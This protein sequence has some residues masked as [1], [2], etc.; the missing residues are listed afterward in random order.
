MILVQNPL[1]RLSG[2]KWLL[3]SAIFCLGFSLT[4]CELFKKL[5]DN[6]KVYKDEKTGLGEIQGP[7][8]TDPVTGETQQIY[9]LVED[10]DTIQWTLSNPEKFPPIQSEA[11]TISDVVFPG[12]DPGDQVTGPR[13]G[14][15]V[16]MVLPFFA[17]QYNSLNANVPT[18]SSWAL[19][20]YAGAKMAMEKLENEG[21]RINFNVV[22]SRGSEQQVQNLINTNGD[23]QQA[24][25]IIGPYR[26]SNARLLADFA[27]REQIFMVSPYSANPFVTKE[28]PYYLQLNPALNAHCESITQH[29]M[30]NYRPEQVILVARNRVD[31][32]ER[33]QLFQQ[34]RIRLS[35]G[36]DT[37]AFQELIIRDESP[38]LIDLDILPYLNAEGPT[39]F[40]VPS[41]NDPN[42]IYSFLR[43]V[44]TGMIDF[45]ED[46]VI[47]GMP[48]WKQYENIDYDLY[49]DLNVHISSATYIDEYNPDIQQFRREFFDLYGQLPSEEAFMGFGTTLYFGRQLKEKGKSFYQQIDTNDANLIHTQYRIRRVFKDPEQFNTSAIE[50][51]ENNFVHILEFLDYY[52]QL[53][54]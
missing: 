46:V 50:R 22:D 45:T 35:Q 48:I 20:F 6:D 12:G 9:V 5:P 16:S 39:V 10:V 49:E 23:L 28:N 2:N 42:F 15:N 21:A 40:I 34:E 18:N 32:I 27:K 30:Q 24:D 33:F 41:Y 3:F 53:A 44:R 51:Y 26:S 43:K 8:T 31:E 13:D 29:V 14:Y 11:T 54:D 37:L 17:N 19:Q 1:P 47:Y 4:S 36:L 25:L 52:F 7:V 38:E